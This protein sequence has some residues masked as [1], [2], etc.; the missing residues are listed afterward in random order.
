MNTNRIPQS[1]SRHDSARRVIA[2]GAA[3]LTAVITGASGLVEGRL[4]NRWAKPVDLVAAGSKIDNVPEHFGDWDL[5]IAR[6]L[7]RTVIDML[8]CAGSTHRIYRNQKTGQV[9]S[10][11]LI[12]GP[13]GPTSAHTPEICYSSRDYDRIEERHKFQ[14][15][16][17]Q[18]PN[19]EFWEVRFRR[20]DL[21]GDVLR[22]A[23]AW[24]SGEGWI[25]PDNPR[26]MFGRYPF[27][28][29]VQVAAVVMTEVDVSE[30]DPCRAFLR[31]ILPELEPVFFSAS[32]AEPSA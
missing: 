26:F 9:V 10:V 6:P 5:Q 24:N 12:V 32:V 16:G 22:V 18:R 7:D 3:I 20:N 17:V 2:L 4:S 15:R 21:R 29:K 23:Y 13:P 8:Q 19:D 1:A 31:D 27:L 28:Y 25:A 30:G 14:V 11:L